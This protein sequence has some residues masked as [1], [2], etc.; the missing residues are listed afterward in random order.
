MPTPLGDTVAPLDVASATVEETPAPVEEVPTREK[1]VPPPVGQSSAPARETPTPVD[2]AQVSAEKSPAPVD[3]SRP[4]SPVVPTESDV[5]AMAAPQQQVEPRNE[6]PHLQ[7]EPDRADNITHAAEKV[8]PLSP[9]M[10]GSP[11]MSGAHIS[12]I[13]EATP[14]SQPFPNKAAEPFGEQR[15]HQRLLKEEPRFS[16]RLPSFMVSLTRKSPWHQ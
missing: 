11:N 5:V 15:H 9:E 2:A 12:P 14:H 3:L 10:P 6:N 1:A 4:I 7:D 16:P 8:G 13:D